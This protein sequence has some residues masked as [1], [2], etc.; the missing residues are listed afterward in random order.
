MVHRETLQEQNSELAQLLKIL[1]DAVRL[2]LEALPELDTLVEVVLDLGRIPEARFA[3]TIVPLGDVPISRDELDHITHAVSDFGSDNRAGI[4]STLHRVS[5]I[6][7]RSGAIVGFTCRVGRAV[8][9]TID[10]LLDIVRSGKSICLLG[11]PGVG[12]TTIL[13]ECA[14]VLAEDRKRVV[15]VDTSNEI[16]G[17]GDI[18]HHGIGQARRMQVT[19]AV[20]QHRVMI[21][22]VEN[23]M[24]EV[25]VIDEIGTEAEAQAARTIAER[26]VQLIGTA[27]GKTLENL[28]MNPTLSDLV[29]GVETVTLSDEEARRRETRK[30]VLE[31]KFPPSFDILI[32]IEDQNRFAIHRD[33]TE[34]VDAILRGQEPR[35]ELRARKSMDDALEPVPAPAKPV[36]RAISE[37][38]FATA[39]RSGAF[40]PKKAAGKTLAIYPFAVSHEKLQ[41]AI[42]ALGLN[43]TIVHSADEADIVFVLPAMKQKF[44]GKLR[45]LAAENVPVI[46]VASKSSDLQAALRGLNPT[47]SGK[48][49]RTLALSKYA[50]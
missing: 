31:R 49:R 1:P 20:V 38:D 19:D 29:G 22:A 46:A 50:G 36:L 16:G 9:G 35:V 23:H 30:T 17:D 27:H 13:R 32:E 25:I 42:V 33:V 41:S 18:P 3:R 26:G 45:S 10:V 8:Y 43:M 4:E 39:M 2:E 24:P 7:N 44:C 11:P 14:R 40:E 48:T 21:E 37:P 12:K 15:I 47:Q 28:L 34:A 6:R 5:A